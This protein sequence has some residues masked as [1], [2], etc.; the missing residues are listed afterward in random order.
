M[1][2]MNTIAGKRITRLLMAISLHYAAFKNEIK[3]AVRGKT[4]LINICPSCD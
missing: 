2:E 3:K 4:D 1:K